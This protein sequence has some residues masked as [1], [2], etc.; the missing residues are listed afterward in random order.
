MYI[1]RA[2]EILGL[3]PGAT[4]E[5]IK[6]AYRDMA[7]VW[8]PD[9]FTNDCRLHR[10]AEEKLREINAAYE[11]LRRYGS[12]ERVN[13]HPHRGPS[14]RATPPQHYPEGEQRAQRSRRVPRWAYPV[15][16]TLVIGLVGFLVEERNPRFVRSDDWTNQ[17]DSDPDRETSRAI[18]EVALPR[19]RLEQPKAN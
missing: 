3:A 1:E 7:K 13:F 14:V 4:T 8:H 17:S 18:S 5:D 15:G 19:P 10:K 9:R 12:G 6:S 2:L 16:V 11:I